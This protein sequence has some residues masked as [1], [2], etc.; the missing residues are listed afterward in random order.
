MSWET[1]EELKLQEG[2]APSLVSLNAFKKSLA[3]TLVG[4]Y[5]AWGELNQVRPPLT[6]S[7]FSGLTPSWQKRLVLE[8]KLIS[9]GYDHFVGRASAA[10]RKR[11]PK[12]WAAL[13]REAHNAM[14]AAAAAFLADMQKARHRQSV[15]GTPRGLIPVVEA[16]GSRPLSAAGVAKAEEPNR[17]PWLWGAGVVAGA[18]LWRRL[19]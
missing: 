3:D 1:T 9:D 7:P 14:S 12:N 17:A 10:V 15:S 2:Q 4:A 6:A 8:H 19:R 5:R 13:V 11:N 16:T 18:L